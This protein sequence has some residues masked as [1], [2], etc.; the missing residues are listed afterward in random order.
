MHRAM[1]GIDRVDESERAEAAA[2]LEA[3][4]SRS[5]V[6]KRDGRLFTR[7]RTDDEVCIPLLFL[8]GCDADAWLRERAAEFMI[9]FGE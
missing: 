9:V 1:W 4:A 7:W 2:I 6:W 3:V 8:S 5:I